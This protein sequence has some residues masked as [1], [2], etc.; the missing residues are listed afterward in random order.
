MKVLYKFASRSR[1]DKFGACLHNIISL[2]RH[3]DFS[4]LCTLDNDDPQATKYRHIMWTSYEQPGRVRA[5]F[6]ESKNKVDAINRDM[7]KAGEWDILIVMSDDMTFL[8]EGFDVEIINDMQKYFPDGDGVLHYHDGNSYGQRLMTM[9]I[10]GRKYYSRFG[11]IYHPDYVSLWCDNEAMEVAMMINKYKW[12]GDNKRLFVH[13]HPVW[14]GEPYD[15]QYKH[16]ESFYYSDKA[17][18]E[19]RKAKFF[20][21]KKQ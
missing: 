10:M 13:R 15:E 17:T 21:L 12:M 3:D 7:D 19:K 14:S 11:Y 2:A 20:D 16:T 8:K 18:Y 1:P 5:I 9:S 6:G 4:I